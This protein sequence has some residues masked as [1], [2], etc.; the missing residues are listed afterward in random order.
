MTYFYSLYNTLLKRSNSVYNPA[1]GRREG[2]LSAS[3][4]SR[5]F[6]THDH[7]LLLLEIEYRCHLLHALL[8]DSSGQR[9]TESCRE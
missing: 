9:R 4:W 1:A 8:R 5:V 7:E 6:E 2:S 3:V